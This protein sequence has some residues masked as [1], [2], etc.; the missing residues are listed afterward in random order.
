M[1]SVLEIVLDN[2]MKRN[3]V[4]SMEIGGARAMMPDV[5]TIMAARELWR[6]MLL[7][8]ITERI[9]TEVVKRKLLPVTIHSLCAL[10]F[11]SLKQF[12]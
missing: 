11:D 7:R 5:N 1:T 10:L 2:M 9:R 12:E 4:G 3:L 8:T 6:E